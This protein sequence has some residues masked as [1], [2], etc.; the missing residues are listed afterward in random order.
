M[1][2]SSYSFPSAE[3]LTRTFNAYSF[4]GDT[5]PDRYQGVTPTDLAEKAWV[6]PPYKGTGV[7]GG[8]GGG[9]I[10]IYSGSSS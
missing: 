10:S 1:A 6:Y 4:T 9:G 7:S 8:A 2:Y 3:F 5:K